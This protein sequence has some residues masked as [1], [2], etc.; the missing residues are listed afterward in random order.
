MKP[1]AAIDVAAYITIK[2][3]GFGK[4]NDLTPMKV[5]KLLYYSQGYYL[6]LNDR[7]LFE[8][9][10]QA[11]KYGPVVASVNAIYQKKGIK[12]ATIILEPVGESANIGRDDHEFLD[13]VIEVRGQFSAYALSNMTHRERPWIETIKMGDRSV[14]SCELMKDYFSGWVTKED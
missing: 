4:E 11:W 10:I 3:K 8:D 1:Y 2:Y 6:A 14:I 13:E 5:H 7:P 9:D 12:G